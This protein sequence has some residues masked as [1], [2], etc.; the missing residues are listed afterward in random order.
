[1]DSK[2]PRLSPARRSRR[3]VL[4]LLACVAVVALAYYALHD[5]TLTPPEAK[6]VVAV[7]SSN[8]ERV[9]AS[10]SGKANK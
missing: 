5:R 6:V 7:S 4:N 3:C 2:Q 10:L 8:L 1:M 9:P